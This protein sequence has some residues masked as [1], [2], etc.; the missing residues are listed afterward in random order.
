M[1]LPWVRRKLGAGP[2]PFARLAEALG[3][4][5]P[6]EEVRV[7]RFEMIRGRLYSLT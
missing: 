7:R 5:C 2:S 3:S 1:G 4:L 6:V